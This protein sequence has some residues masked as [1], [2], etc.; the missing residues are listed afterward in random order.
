MMK[1]VYHT[2]FLATDRTHDKF[3]DETA[4][5][6]LLMAEQKR[7]SAILLQKKLDDG[8]QGYEYRCYVL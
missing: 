2:G 8:R 3:L 4:T 6:Y 1:T 5:K 7:P